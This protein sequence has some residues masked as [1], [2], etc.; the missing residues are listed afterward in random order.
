MTRLAALAG[1]IPA[2]PT[3]HEGDVE[4]VLDRFEILLGWG[5]TPEIEPLRPA[6][7]AIVELVRAGAPLD[8]IY[9]DVV[10]RA[11]DERAEPRRPGAT[12]ARASR[13]MRTRGGTETSATWAR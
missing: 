5:W 9:A 11:R 4:R 13:R 6:T 2:A 1:E 10:A 8:A 7:A 3:F 12:F